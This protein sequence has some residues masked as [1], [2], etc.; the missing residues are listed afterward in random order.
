MKRRVYAVLERYRQY[1]AVIV[2][3]HGTL[4]QYV[5]DIPHP[6]NGEIA[7]LVL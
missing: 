7:A 4:M 3:C 6:K 2:V 5:L 1:T